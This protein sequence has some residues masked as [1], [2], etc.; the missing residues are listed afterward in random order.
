MCCAFW[1]QTVPVY[2]GAAIQQQKMKEQMKTQ[3]PRVNIRPQITSQSPPGSPGAPGSWPEVWSQKPEGHKTA[4]EA[5]R[6]SPYEYENVDRATQEK[7]LREALKSRSSSAE[8]ESSTVLESSDP[9]VISEINLSD[10][11]AALQTS[12]QSWNQIIDVEAKALI[13]LE[14]IKLY[15]KHGVTISQPPAYYAFVIDTIAGQSPEILDNS[16]DRVLQLAAVMDYDFDNGQDKDM[17]AQQ[18]LGERGYLANKQRL[19]A[20]RQQ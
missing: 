4:D 18:L 3:R 6:P 16:F 9:E 19:Q 11:I 17:L 5:S 7:A 2:A 13:V 10:I 1:G 14:F 12:S 20:A 8:Y 15:E